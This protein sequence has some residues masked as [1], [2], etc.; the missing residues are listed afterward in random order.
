MAKICRKDYFISH[1]DRQDQEIGQIN[2]KKITNERGKNSQQ[3][4]DEIYENNRDQVEYEIL[5]CDAMFFANEP[6]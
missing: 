2:I 4:I 3:V 1:K 6:E 5:Q